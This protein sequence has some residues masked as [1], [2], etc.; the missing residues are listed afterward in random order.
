MK[1]V[2]DAYSRQEQRRGRLL[3][4]VGEQVLTNER[5]N[6]E[7]KNNDRIIMHLRIEPDSLC[8]LNGAGVAR[9]RP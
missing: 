5:L 6:N 8:W 9:R 2:L 4:V 1:R 7:N 3:S